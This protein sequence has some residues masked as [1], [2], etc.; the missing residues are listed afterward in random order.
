MRWY[1]LIVDR[2]DIC[3][4]AFVL[5]KDMNQAI[6]LCAKMGAKTTF[7]DIQVD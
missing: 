5:L 7:V 3:V 2:I 1:H 6:L 4:Q